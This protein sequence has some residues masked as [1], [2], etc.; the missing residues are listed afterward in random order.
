[1]CTERWDLEIEK[2]C[3]SW[4]ELDNAE[5]LMRL[6]ALPMILP[7]IKDWPASKGYGKIHGISKYIKFHKEHIKIAN[8]FFIEIHWSILYS[9][10]T[11]DVER[12][13]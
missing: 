11:I 9:M 2:K 5:R 6:R 13:A 10:Q 12:V 8:I 4:T 7:L 3:E 1:L